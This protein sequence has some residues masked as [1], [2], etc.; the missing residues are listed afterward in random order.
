[1]TPTTDEPASVPRELPS[2]AP[3]CVGELLDR[4]HTITT[5]LAA[6]RST[7]PY[8]L[9]ALLEDVELC[10]AMR[11]SDD[12]QISRGYDLLTNLIAES[13]GAVATLRA[14][15]VSDRH[16]VLERLVKT[17]ETARSQIAAT[18]AEAERAGDA[19]SLFSD[20]CSN[21]AFSTR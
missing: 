8:A 3:R 10:P 6:D 15:P 14:C 13:R 18:A 20:R 7:G 12:P 19:Q 11:K 5:K 4:L 17:I 16:W 1:M 2:A 21:C 9:D